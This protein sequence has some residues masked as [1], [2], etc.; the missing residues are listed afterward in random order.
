MEVASRFPYE[1][2]KY[3]DRKDRHYYATTVL[4]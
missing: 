2:R 4:F 3:E 1:G